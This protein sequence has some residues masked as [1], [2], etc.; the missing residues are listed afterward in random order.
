[1]FIMKI[2]GITGGIASGKSMV[3]SI[4]QTLGAKIIDC[5][6]VAKE[7]VMKG[8]PAYYEL[9]GH[10]G[11]NVLKVDGEIDRKKLAEIVFNN[12]D[13][14]LAINNITHKYVYIE[15]D[16]IIEEA[17]R[18]CTRILAV[19]ASVPERNLFRSL[20]DE[21]WTVVSNKEDRINRVIERDSTTRGKALKR[22]ESQMADQ[23]Y[24]KMADH[25]IMNTGNKDELKEIVII[26]Y[27]N[28]IG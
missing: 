22:I 2:I 16:N 13:E 3:S 24:M 20:T 7:I 25:V 23:E 19:E 21:V 1:M 15:L 27:N 11:E 28:I 6:I 5:D 14:R 8:R 9:I 12:K 18:D 17:K 26:L 4:L 10:F